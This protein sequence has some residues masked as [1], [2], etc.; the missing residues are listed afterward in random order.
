[1]LI[2]V[3]RTTQILASNSGAMMEGNDVCKSLCAQSLQVDDHNYGGCR[4]IPLAVDDE[5]RINE[6][7]MNLIPRL[8]IIGHYTFV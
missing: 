3:F 8:Y 4:Q 6:R 5:L 7:L 1:M 2:K